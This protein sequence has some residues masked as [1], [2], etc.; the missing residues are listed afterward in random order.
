MIAIIA[1]LAAI[2]FPVF[3]QAKAAAKSTAAISNAKQITTGM[4]IYMADSEDRFVPVNNW[5]DSGNF[6]G[7]SS[8]VWAIQP[9]IKSADLF[10]DP[11][12][13]R[14]PRNT[15][16]GY[17]NQITLTPTFGYNY[18]MASPFLG[19][20]PLVAPSPRSQSELG[21]PSNSV[22][23]TGRFEQTSES[24]LDYGAYYSY[25]NIGP[26]TSAIVDPPDCATSIS[27]CFDNWGVGSFWNDEGFMG[28]NFTAGGL[29]GGTSFRNAEKATVGFA[30][31]SVRKLSPGALAA[32]TNWTRTLNSSALTI[33]DREQYIWDEL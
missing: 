12:A 24:N 14:V 1:I 16:F 27:W 4:F 20:T 10:E 25:G 8:W 17:V 32:G 6:I 9:Y 26:D 21:S 28:I 31:G 2:L 18:T 7:Y 29:T 23:L 30:D 3:A 22:L 13:P 33:T 5:D 15:P 11:Q 19:P